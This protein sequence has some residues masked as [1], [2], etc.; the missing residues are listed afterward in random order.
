MG[1]GYKIL[2][3][4]CN[5]IENH[6][7]FLHR[8]SFLFFLYNTCVCVCA[9]TYMHT[10]MRRPEINLESCSLDVIHI[11]YLGQ[12]LSLAWNS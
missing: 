1:E 7:K 9:R 10:H 11:V 2:H 3:N 5:F 6:L 12:T 8:N 4:L